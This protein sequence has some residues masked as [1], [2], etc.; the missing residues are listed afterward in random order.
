M[1][2]FEYCL[3]L[4]LLALVAVPSILRADPADI[5]PAGCAVYGEARDLKKFVAD[6][7]RAPV[8]ARIKQSELFSS[9][10]DTL[11][12]GAR[13]LTA[14]GVGQPLSK[15]YREHVQGVACFIDAVPGARGKAAPRVTFIVDPGPRLKE[16][17]I[18]I[19]GVRPRLRSLDK[20]IR[21]DRLTHRNTTIETVT[22]AH[23]KK[24]SHAFVGN[25]WVVGPL[26]AVQATV[27]VADGA[28]CSL[29]ADPLFAAARA[30]QGGL[31]WF[32]DL[33][34]AILMTSLQSRKGSKDTTSMGIK[35]LKAM[36]SSLAADP[37]GFT[38]STALD[39][40]GSAGG[41]LALLRN[42]QTPDIRAF[43][44]LPDTYDVIFAA[45]LGKGRQVHRVIADMIRQTEGPAAIDKARQQAAQVQAFLGIDLMADI[46]D[47]FTGEI[48][49][50]FQIPPFATEPV[51]GGIQ[52]VA[53]SKPVFGIGL[54]DTRA[55][56]QTLERLLAQP[57]L[58]DK[59]FS[60]QFD[61]YNKVTCYKLGVPN[62]PLTINYAFL[63]SRWVIAFDPEGLKTVID[64]QQSGKVAG[65]SPKFRALL[66]AMPRAATL[67][68]LTDPSHLVAEAIKK[69]EAKPERA[70]G[71][72]TVLPELKKISAAYTGL[73]IACSPVAGGLKID[74]V[75]PLGEPF[76]LAALCS[77]APFA[78]P[79]GSAPADVVKTYR[80]L[81]DTRRA[82]ERYRF[83]NKLYP[84][85]LA[86]LV[87]FY[88]DKVPRDPF[89]ANRSVDYLATPDGAQ[90]LL[91]SVGP[92][93][94][95]DLQLAADD[96]ATF[97]RQVRDPA[98]DVSTIDQLKPRLYR[99]RFLTNSDENAPDDEGD[100]ILLSSE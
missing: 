79:K 34:G 38:S 56:Q 27:D 36:S 51:M 75:S 35:G 40:G 68:I 37:D 58:K 99:Y 26:E 45:D 96:L 80:I 25:Y 29:A 4:F 74:S 42:T 71:V 17:E 1:K 100:I 11:W 23:G 63:D 66:A 54:K 52:L 77:F 60:L 61:L 19:A 64:A 2:R 88:L 18:L 24:I 76:L 87:P 8:A 33:E 91:K 69:V 89:D 59:G 41:I 39:F 78:P 16:F 43:N 70:P 10:F 46:V 22:N 14:L 57:G 6:L 62:V 47:Q 15:I 50:G 82:L 65:V 30:R 7:D 21:F 49:V 3:I 13:F 31:F 92:D 95:P 32:T 72:A 98:V 83:K 85:R 55:F 53:A 90:F 48:F 86:Q 84:E 97:L 9:G 20:K 5:T 12:D 93:R 81:L 67:R 94:Q 28:R 73:A 44:I